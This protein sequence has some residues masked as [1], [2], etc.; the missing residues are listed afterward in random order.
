MAIYA[1]LGVLLVIAALMGARSFVNANPAVLARAVRWGGIG[2]VG[3]AGG[4]LAL[5]GRILLALTMAPALLAWLRQRS[6][7]APGDGSARRDDGPAMR[8]GA[9]SRAEAFEVLG[10]PPDADAVAIKAAHHRLIGKIHPDLGGST[11]LAAKI[12][13]AKDVLLDS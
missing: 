1:A 10:L 5:T 4:Y 3:V 2:L 13:Q 7:A 11:Y 9:M 12:N 6:E 8:T